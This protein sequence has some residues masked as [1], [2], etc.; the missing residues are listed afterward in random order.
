MDGLPRFAKP[1]ID[2]GEKVEIAAMDPGFRL[3]P[4]PLPLMECAGRYLYALSS[5]SLHVRSRFDLPRSDLP[6]HHV[7]IA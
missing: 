2:D 1:S 6:C 4:P 7:M 3:R 5:F